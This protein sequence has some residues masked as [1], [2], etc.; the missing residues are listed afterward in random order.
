MKQDKIAFTDLDAEREVLALLMNHPN[1]TKDIQKIINPDVFHFSTTKSVYLTCVELFSEKGT[2][3]QSDIIIRLK[4]K[5]SNDWVDVMMA[6]TTRTPMNAQEVILYLA[7]LKGKRDLLA[8]SREV[9]NSLVNGEDY[10]TIVDKIN[11]VTSNELIQNDTNEV[12]DMKSALSDAI[13]NIGDVMT[14][15]SLS[16]VPTG[17]NILDNVTGGWLKGNV[18]LF[19]ARP[20]QGKCFAKGTKIRMYDG[21]VKNVEDI[22]NGELVMGNDSS[23][24]EVY[25]TTSG[26]EEMFEIKTNKGEGFIC[27]KSH[28]LSLVYNKDGVNAEYG[29]NKDSV[30]NISVGEYLKLKPWVQN[31][32][33]LYSN[34]WG[35]EYSEKTHDIPP[36]LLG[37][38]LGDGTSL[39]G[40]ITSIDPEIISYFDNY[41]NSIGCKMVLADRITYRINK[42]KGFLKN[43]YKQFLKDIDV[44]GN[45]HIPKEYLIDSR[46]NR[47]ELLAGLIDTDGSLNIVRGN[48][49]S[50]EITQK[51]KILAYNIL[52]LSRSLGFYS[53]INKRLSKMK[54]I[55]GSIYECETYRVKIYGEL[56]EVP[57]K[58]HR[59]QCPKINRRV[60]SNRYGFKIKSLGIGEYY[61]FAV[62]KNHLFLLENGIVVH[63]T[64]CLLEHSRCAGEMNK[65][66]LFLSLEMPVVSLVYRMISGQ[67]DDSTPYS[68]IKTGRIDINQFNNIQKQAVTNLEKLPI[69]WYDGANRDINYLSTLIQKIV[70]EKNID[71]VVVDYLQLITDN[72]IRSNDETAVV[73]SVSKKIQQLAKKLNIPFLCA[74]QLNRQSEGRTSHRPKL[75]DLRSSGQIEQDASVVIGLYRDDYYKYEKAK[76]E[77]NPNVVYDNVIEYIFMKNRDGDTRTADLYIDVA[78]SKIREVNPTY[79]SPGF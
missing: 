40:D 50:Y 19:A 56:S 14:N 60:N 33:K 57:C 44:L 12:L 61:G 30:V 31:R 6:S 10:F 76:E 16:G 70:R 35:N 15:G 32:L 20:G 21:S 29:W 71:M 79:S 1:Y 2:F 47:L 66:V 65:K 64:I 26:V 51:R 78:T 5:G 36:Y 52:E 41:A 49:D 34:E 3:T 72:S 17:Y 58:I 39:K 28:I 45:K 8:L 7:E 73:G 24:R 68:K 59:K 48:F 69:T 46:K 43:K 77:G 13:N 11:N 4:S 53:S 9:N 25:G 38:F 74:A 54:R 18:I 55:D 63:N 22:T 23:S 27:N 42:Q 75:S 67:L 62:D 37:V